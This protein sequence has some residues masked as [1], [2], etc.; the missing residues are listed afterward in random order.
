MHSYLLPAC[1]P[2]VDVSWQMICMH[3]LGYNWP[4]RCI[5][6]AAFSEAAKNTLA[7]ACADAEAYLSHVA[8]STLLA[9]VCMWAGV[10]VMPPFT[11]LEGLLK[12]RHA[13]MPSCICTTFW[14]RQEATSLPPACT[15]CSG[16]KHFT[17]Y[18][19]Y[20]DLACALRC[21]KTLGPACLQRL[22]LEGSR[23]TRE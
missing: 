3:C 22:F 5:V 6:R 11:S 1:K 15:S 23:G 16:C 21:F 9:A 10:V 12:Q 7:R 20:I 13:C 4:C 2:C 8:V 18:Y 17:L 19:V 14:Q